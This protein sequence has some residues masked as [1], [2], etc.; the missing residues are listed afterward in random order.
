MIIN[1][2]QIVASDTPERLS[3]RLSSDRFR[4]RVKGETEEIL[5]AFNSNERI[6]TVTTEESAEE[7]AVDLLITGKEGTDPRETAFE[8]AKENGF[9]LLLIKS[10]KLTLEE[11]FLKVTEN[12]EAGIAEE[13]T[14]GKEEE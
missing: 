8:I 10:E 3:D 7:V 12:A 4:I 13:E 9:T 11:V 2:G 14:E 1:K 5:K 6:D